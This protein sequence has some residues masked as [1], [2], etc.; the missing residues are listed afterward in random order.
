MHPIQPIICNLL[1]IRVGPVS[2]AEQ[3]VGGRHM[4]AP[5]QQAYVGIGCI[6]GPLISVEPRYIKASA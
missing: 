1:L 4:P 6:M 3:S 2:R 5:E